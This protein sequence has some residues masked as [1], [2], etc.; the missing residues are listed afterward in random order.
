MFHEWCSG[1]PESPPRC[2]GTHGSAVGFPDHIIFLGTEAAVLIAEP[3]DGMVS[4]ASHHN[5]C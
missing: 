2:G 4:S 1:K 5:W 3:A